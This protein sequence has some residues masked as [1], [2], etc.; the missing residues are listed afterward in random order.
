[1]EALAAL[2]VA[3][4]TVQFLDFATR[5]CVTS[6]NIYQGV[7]GTSA[8]NAQAEA[9]LKSFI[10]TIDEVSSNLGQYCVALGAASE[11]ASGRGEARISS[12][13]TDCQ[14]IAEDLL[15]R[16]DKLKSSGKPGIWKSFVAGVKCTWR[17]HELEDLEDRLRKNR[18]ELE[19]CILLS[20]RY[21]IFSVN[22]PRL[23]MSNTTPG[24]A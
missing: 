2:G 7:N 12:I 19:W 24:K 1:M 21:F 8:S 10:E 9:L 13:I 16:F 6:I 18:S 4:N 20:L 23:V 17:K 15:R 3:G 22:S 14:A 11:Q 5:L